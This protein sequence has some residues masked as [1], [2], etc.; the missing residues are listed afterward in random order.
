MANQT[1]VDCPKCRRHYF[2]QKGS[3]PFCARPMEGRL[4][5]MAMA[6]MTPMVLGACYGSPYKDSGTGLFGTT[7]T[8]GTTGG[9]AGD[10]SG[11][12]GLYIESTCGIIWDM[13]GPST[14]DL[15]WDVAM[16]VNAATDCAGAAD[17]AG[18]FE[19]SG[20]SAYFENSYVGTATYGGGAVAWATSGYVTGGG[21]GSYYYAG[22]ATY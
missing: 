10:I 15:S 20:G 12:Y 14:G 2:V 22:S 3:C 1:L 11:T 17:T 8:T 16:T 19:V 5:K 13:S 18:S 21:G 4:A 9:P 7:G 6:A